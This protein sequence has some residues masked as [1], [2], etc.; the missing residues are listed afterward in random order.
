MF[1]RFSVSSNA[2]SSDYECRFRCKG[3][4]ETNTLLNEINMFPPEIN[5][6]F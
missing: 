5:V 1:S 3:L 2:E 4:S 6:F